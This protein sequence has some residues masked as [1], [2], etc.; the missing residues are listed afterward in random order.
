MKITKVLGYQVL[1]SR[2]R[3]TVAAAITLE[4]GAT[5][6]ARVPSGASTG[7]HEAKELRD[8]ATAISNKFYSGKSVNQAVSN[9]NSVIAPELQNMALSLNDVVS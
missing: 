8:G 2:G 7:K 4:N 9:I 3:P 1:D 6:T 5:H